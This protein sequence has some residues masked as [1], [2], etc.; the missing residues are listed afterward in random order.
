MTALRVIKIRVKYL[1]LLFIIV[2]FFFSL[3]KYLSYSIEQKTIETLSTALAGKIIVVDPGHGGKDRGAQSKNGTLEK[4]I[5]LEVS[6]RLTFMLEQAGADVVMTREADVWLANPD[7]PHKKRSDL[8]NRVNIA[9]NKNANVF[10]SIHT[11][12]F[13]VDPS[14][15]GAQVFSQPGDEK[16]KLLAQCVQAELKRIL[17]NTDRQPKQIDY[18]IRNSKV[19]AVIVEMGF[20]SNQKD[21]K[22][23]LDSAYQSKMAYAIYCGLVKYFSEKDEYK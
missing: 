15:K 4:D 9:N 11:N 10:I 8:L 1:L 12:S 6:R 22:L 3:F 16:S 23:L 19:P 20:L 14:E 13:P 18:F 21:E 7:A 5:N 17:N 2:V